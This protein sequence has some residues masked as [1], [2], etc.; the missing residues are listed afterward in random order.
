M[1][2]P[3][4]N[5]INRLRKSIGTPENVVRHMEAVAAYLETLLDKLENAGFSYDRELLRASALLHD[6]CRLSPRH[7][8]AGAAFL[9][10]KGY[11]EIA[12]LVEDHH[13]PAAAPDKQEK[14]FLPPSPADLLF[15]ADK[16]VQGTEIVTIEERFEASRTKC[17]TDE[18]VRNHDGQLSR[19]GSVEEKIRKCTGMLSLHPGGTSLTVEM[20]GEAG[21][22]PGER[23]LDIGCGTGRSIMLLKDRFGIL[24]YGLD[25][26]DAVLSAAKEVFPEGEFILG[27]AANLPYPDAFFD[28]ALMECVL[29]LFDDPKFA[30]REASRVLKPGGVL[31]LSTLAEKSDPEAVL[32]LAEDLPLSCICAEDRKKELTHYMI[33][34]ILQYGS[35]EERIAAEKA[36]TGVSVLD[37]CRVDP[38]NTTYYSFIFRKA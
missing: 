28:A 37:G 38:E 35:L 13:R 22:Q 1:I 15:Y 7:A 24:P 26:S 8:E 17:G 32:R 29:T 11:P 4:A 6:I 3:D 2:L 12:E 27:D 31:L 19:A 16:R 33:D 25:C 36:V 9:R 20:A 21:L 5:E 14:R 18:A 10:E 23:V 34:T 30:L